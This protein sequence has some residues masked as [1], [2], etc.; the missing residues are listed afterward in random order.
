MTISTFEDEFTEFFK[1]VDTPVKNFIYEK[2]MQQKI[3]RGYQ[4]FFESFLVLYGVYAFSTFPCQFGGNYIP[5]INCQEHNVFGLK[6]GITDIT[7]TSLPLSESERELAKFLI[8]QFDN[9]P[10][11]KLINWIKE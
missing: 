4:S 6:A 5:F 8:E 10:V 1:E 9:M 11:V 7:T 3:K 2:Y